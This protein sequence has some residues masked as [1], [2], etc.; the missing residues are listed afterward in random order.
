MFTDMVGY[1]AA[2]QHDE[3]Q[4]LRLLQ[5]Q[6][7]LVRPILATHR[8]REVKSTGD[9]L[10]VEFDSALQATEC[11]I[12]IQRR[13]SARNAE[14]GR[15]PIQ[16]RIGIHLG[17]VEGR[18]QDILGDAVNIA[19][20]VVPLAA[21]GGICV[22][23]AVREQVWN[24][25]AETLEKLPSREL[26]GLQGPTDVFRV[27]WSASPRR[28]RPEPTE[29]TGIAVLPF[30]NI[31]PDLKDEFF[32]DGLTE[33]VI[34]VLSQIRN[35]R[36]ISRTSVMQYKATTK[37]ATQIGAELGV[38]SLLEGSV[39]KSGSRL[40]ITAQ[41]I[42][43]RDDRHIWAQGYDRELDDVFEVQA[44]LAK[45]VAQALEVELR[46]IEAARLESRRAVSP[47]SYLAY[48]KGRTLMHSLDRASLEAAKGQFERSIE[49]DPSNGA[50]HSGLADI[51]RVI[52]W[53]VVGAQRAEYHVASRQ[54]ASRAIELDPDLA[55]AH[56][57]LALAWWDEYA[58][59]AAEQEFKRAL[60][61][62]PSYSLAHFW[63]GDVLAEQARS[64]EAVAEFTL[65]EGADPLW[66]LN[67]TRLAAVLCWIGRP[68]SALAP[69]EKLRTLGYEEREYHLA[70]AWY[71]LARSEVPKF[72]A[73]VRRAVDLEPQSRLKEALGAWYAS[74][75]G[76][77]DEARAFL[78]R[79]EQLP[80][81]PQ[82]AWVVAIVYG[83]LRD[84]ENCFRW[85][86][87]AR[88]F[89][90]LPLQL[91][92]LAPR[93][94]SIRTDPKFRSFLAKMNLS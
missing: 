34:T 27:V 18:G 53:F 59:G 47:E 24:K 9:G 81:V 19:A 30:S 13:I 28:S 93:F 23:G 72:L 8:G 70:L 80:E 31:S 3:R 26:K 57:S 74:L 84:L 77:T 38:A 42:D 48:L 21:P 6:E 46:P 22:S 85:L 63:Y 86:E 79:E 7:E 32:A 65:A 67:L 61:L 64:E 35:L 78:R 41:L 73:E 51:V 29:P 37:S 4:T 15:L 12:E 92:R 1:T 89:H 87:K 50:A 55:E 16:L 75:S 20:R 58:Y 76:A 68:E 10:L 36:V 94:D 60:A 88:E 49:L 91:L 69:L 54:H 14:P 25:I 90:I 45:Q 83:E 52:G 17:D 62:N 2:T 5:D 40:R 66:G 11:A 56:A 33:E 82:T 44:E 43:A 71:H 39:R